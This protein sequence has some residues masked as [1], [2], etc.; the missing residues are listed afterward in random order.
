[1]KKEELKSMVA[2]GK[3]KEVPAKVEELLEAGEEPEAIMKNAL[4]PAM[5][6]PPEK[7]VEAVKTHNPPVLGMSALPT[8]TMLAMKET[9][10]AI[11]DAG[12]RDK[13]KIMIGGAPVRKEFA[14]EIGAD[15]Y[16]PDSTAGKNFAREVVSREM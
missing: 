1:M 11:E 13:V 5:D 7:F 14:G 16:G 2:K 3:T 10:E 9:I 4:I 15:F 12:L 8:A 6:V